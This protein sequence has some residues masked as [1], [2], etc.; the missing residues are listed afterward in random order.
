MKNL[1]SFF[2]AAFLLAVGGCWYS[3]TIGTAPF[4]F[5][6]GWPIL[7]FSETQ[8]VWW[9]AGLI[10]A[11]LWASVFIQYQSICLETGCWRNNNLYSK[12][13]IGNSIIT[14]LS[15]ATMLVL[16]YHGE[17]YFGPYALLEF[18]ILNDLFGFCLMGLFTALWAVMATVCYP[19]VRPALPAVD[20]KSVWEALFYGHV[21]TFAFILFV[22]ICAHDAIWD[23]N[24]VFWVPLAFI[25][26]FFVWAAVQQFI[27]NQKVFMSFAIIF[28]VLVLGWLLNNLFHINYLRFIWRQLIAIYLVLLLAWDVGRIA[29]TY[30]FWIKKEE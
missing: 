11:V 19:F 10:G 4:F 25:W 9:V 30:P 6:A 18:L 16:T 29:K 17:R 24:P 8:S 22:S 15:L 12:L 5:R 14:A 3:G 21:K 20:G 13:W 1:K 7:M 2:F 26:Y 28:F 27:P 23:E